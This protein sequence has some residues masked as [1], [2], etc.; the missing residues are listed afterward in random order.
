MATTNGAVENVSVDGVTQVQ[1]MMM[2]TSNTLI[3]IF[4]G[5]SFFWFRLHCIGGFHIIVAY[6][7]ENEVCEQWSLSVLPALFLSSIKFTPRFFNFQVGLIFSP[8]E[9]T[10]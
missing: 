3:L 5:F 10:F 6:E 1:V 7:W 2:Q 4:P 9:K 8:C